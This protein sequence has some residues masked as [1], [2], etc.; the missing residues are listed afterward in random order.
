MSFHSDRHPM[1]DLQE[2][3]WEIS[4]QPI[5]LH[6]YFATLLL[7]K[8]QIFGCWESSKRVVL[9]TK[10]MVLGWFL[11][12]RL[13]GKSYQNIPKH[14]L[15]RCQVAGCLTALAPPLK[16]PDVRIPGQGKKAGKDWIFFQ[17]HTASLGPKRSTVSGLG[18]FGTWDLDPYC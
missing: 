11:Y 2:L 16:P 7:V 3:S 15:A 4:G 10:N 6:R 18:M 5:R 8:Y 14:R 1:A 12:Q 17:T 9:Y 13:R